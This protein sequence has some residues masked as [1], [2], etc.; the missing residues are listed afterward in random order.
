MWEKL[1]SLNLPQRSHWRA[2]LGPE[3]IRVVTNAGQYKEGWKFQLGMIKWT[4]KHDQSLITCV[5]MKPPR[6]SIGSG[7]M[8]VLFFSA[9]IEWRVCRYLEL[10]SSSSQSLGGNMIMTHSHR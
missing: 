1:L 2:F 4:K 10:F 8:I 6:S 9:E 7:K 5:S 3:N